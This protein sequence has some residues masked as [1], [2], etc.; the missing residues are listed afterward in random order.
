MCQGQRLYYIFGKPDF[1]LTSVPVI[2][3]QIPPDSSDASDITQAQIAPMKVPIALSSSLKGLAIGFR[4]MNIFSF[5]MMVSAAFLV[6]VLLYFVISLCS[7][8]DFC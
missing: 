7:F 8:P 4:T 1:L 3:D 5:I 6:A 2:L